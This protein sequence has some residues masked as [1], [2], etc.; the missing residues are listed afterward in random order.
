M[1]HSRALLTALR[2]TRGS[3]ARAGLLPPAR[4]RPRYELVSTPL[5]VALLRQLRHTT[6]STQ[7]LGESPASQSRVEEA[8]SEDSRNE[9]RQLVEDLEETPCEALPSWVPHSQAIFSLLLIF[10]QRVLAPHFSRAVVL[11]A[12]DSALLVR[13]ARLIHEKIPH[14]KSTN[15]IEKDDNETDNRNQLAL[16]ALRAAIEANETWVAQHSLGQIL[17]EMGR[18]NEVVS[19]IFRKISRFLTMTAGDQCFRV[20]N[21]SEQ[22]FV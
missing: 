13:I 10:M 9:L 1:S 7:S 20:G 19:V 17:A 12:G 18:H 4:P 14:S 15:E 22:R 6:S 11:F 16:K 2:G 21:L 5:P 8:E 3:R